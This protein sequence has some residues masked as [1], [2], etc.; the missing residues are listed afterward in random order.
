[1]PTF[2]VTGPLRR[3]DASHSW[4]ARVEIVA[5]GNEADVRNL[6]V[7]G[8]PIDGVFT[9]GMRRVHLPGTLL[10]RVRVSDVRVEF[11]A[12]IVWSWAGA[13]RPVVTLLV[14]S[15]PEDSLSLEIADRL[16]CVA[17]EIALE[18]PNATV[19]GNHATDWPQRYL[20]HLANVSDL[21]A[22]SSG[23][24]VSAS[25]RL[26]WLDAADATASA[27]ARFHILFPPQ[28][29]PGNWMIS[30]DR[31]SLTAAA[32]AS[33]VEKFAEFDRILTGARTER[34]PAEPRPK[35]VRLS[36]AGGEIPQFHYLTRPAANPPETRLILPGGATR[37]IVCAQ[38]D[39]G[40]DTLQVAPQLT[41]KAD[42]NGQGIPTGLQFTLNME[43][44]RPVQ[45]PL[46]SGFAGF[47]AGDEPPI[48]IRAMLS[49]DDGV[50]AWRDP[51][52][53]T[54]AMVTALASYQ[55]TV[56]DAE[57]RNA[58]LTLLNL[59]R[60]R[61][62]GAFGSVAYVA[63][64]PAAPGGDFTESFDIENLTTVYDPFEAATA[65]RAREGLPTPDLDASPT[66]ANCGNVAIT[67]SV[68]WGVLPLA[69]GWAQ[70]PFL[71]L[72][73]ETFLR[74]VDFDESERPLVPTLLQGAATFGNESPGLWP[75]D[76][77]ENRWS[78]SLLDAARIDG[79]WTIRRD[80]GLAWRP[81]RLALRFRDPEAVINGLLQLATKPPSQADCL[82]DFDAWLTA[83][84]RVSLRTPLDDDRFRS[85]YD[86]VLERIRLARRPF[87]L[88]F[89]FDAGAVPTV[90]HPATRRSLTIV[91]GRMTWTG[92]EIG[93]GVLDQLNDWKEDAAYGA[94]FRGALVRLLDR[95]G[96]LNGEPYT[97]IEIADWK[98]E[99]RP[100]DLLTVFGES[101]HYP[102]VHIKTP[103]PLV[104][105]RHPTLPAVQSLPMTQVGRPPVY[106]SANRQLVPFQFGAAWKFTG[107]TGDW[108]DVENADLQVAEEWAAAGVGTAF[109]PLSALSL[110]GLAGHAADQPV[111]EAPIGDDFLPWEY[112]YGLPYLDE[113]YALAGLP[114]EPAHSDD[115]LVSTSA[116]GPPPVES[117]TPGRDEY[118]AY[119]S[120]LAEKGFLAAAD[121]DGAI[122][123]SDGDPNALEVTGLV[124][125][126]RWPIDVDVDVGS[127]PGSLTFT[128]AG[129]SLTIGRDDA[130]GLP[131]RGIDAKFQLNVGGSLQLD[132][133]GPFS[134]VSG[135]LA[136]KE[137]GG[138]R[139]DQRGLTH[140]ATTGSPIANPEVATTVLRFH[141]APAAAETLL[142][143][144]SLFADC[145]LSLGSLDGAVWRL[146]FRDLP[147]DD[148]DGFFERFRSGSDDR[149]GVNDPGA[150]GR[151]YNFRNGYEWRLAGHDNRLGPFD[152]F[153][154]TLEKVKFEA[155][156]V[157]AVE[158]TGRLQLPQVDD[159]GGA[160]RRPQAGVSNAV[161]LSF[162]AGGG[163]ALELSAVAIEPP[164]SIGGATVAELVWPLAATEG[165]PRVVIRRLMYTA[166]GIQMD[167]LRL[168]FGLFG[169][170][171]SVAPITPPPVTSAT[172]GIELRWDNPGLVDADAVGVRSVLASLRFPTAVAAPHSLTLE[173]EGRWGNPDTARIEARAEWNLISTDRPRTTRRVLKFADRSEIELLPLSSEDSR[174][175]EG[176]FQI[177]WQSLGVGASPPDL[178]PGFTPDPDKAPGYAVLTFISEPAAVA[179]S[180]PR[181]V[182][183]SGFMEGIFRCRRPGAP[184]DA[185][186]VFGSSEGDVDAGL[187]YR[188][189]GSSWRESLLLNGL[190]TIRNLISWPD[191]D[192][193]ALAEDPPRVVLPST[194]PIASRPLTHYRHS[195]KV[196][197]N[198]VELTDDHLA[199]GTRSVFTLADSK[200]V[201]SFPT[202]V[203]HELKRVALA[204]DGATTPE[205]PPAI[206]QT[207]DVRTWTAM[208]EVRLLRPRFFRTF[209]ERFASGALFAPPWKNSSVLF[210]AL[211]FTFDGYLH[212]SFLDQVRGSTILETLDDGGALLVEMSSVVGLRSLSEPAATAP[213]SDIRRSLS[214][215]LQAASAT[216]DDFASDPS[217]RSPWTPVS[218]PFLSRLQNSADD[219]LS[220]DSVT[221]LRV[222]PLLI[223]HRQRLAG[224]ALCRTSLNLASRADGQNVSLR[225]G[226]FDAPARQAI[227]RL[228][229]ATLEEQWFRLTTAAESIDRDAPAGGITAAPP[230]D[231][232][233]RLSRPAFLERLFDPLRVAV[234]P[235]HG[236]QVDPEPESILWRYGAL[237]VQDFLVPNSAAAA[238]SFHGAGAQ[239]LSALRRPETADSRSRSIGVTLLP[240]PMTDRPTPLLLQPV[241][242]AVCPYRGVGLLPPAA[243]LTE[244]AAVFTEILVRER[245]GT[246]PVVLRARLWQKGEK[247]EQPG[248]SEPIDD[249]LIFAWATDLWER[250]AGD[251]LVCVLRMR[252]FFVHPN[253]AAAPPGATIRIAYRFELLARSPSDRQPDFEPSPIRGELG[254][255][256]FAEPGFSENEPPAGAT[257]VGL[258]P[259]RVRSVTPQYELTNPLRAFSGITLDIDFTR[260][261]IGMTGPLLGPAEWRAWWQ[262][263][264]LR[265]QFADPSTDAQATL[266][267]NF[268]SRAIRSLAVA[269]PDLPLPA[270]G[271]LPASVGGPSPPA[272]WQPVLPGSVRWTGIGS[273]AGAF[274]TARPQIISQPADGPHW[275]SGSVPVQHRFPRPVPI[276]KNAGGGQ[277]EA[278][279]P[280]AEWFDLDDASLVERSVAA[281]FRPTDDAF[282]FPAGGPAG[283][284]A[285]FV[286]PFDFDRGAVPLERWRG[287]NTPEFTLRFDKLGNMATD[288]TSDIVLN[289]GDFTVACA[290]AAA[291]P[292]DGER[293]YRVQ[294][295]T[296]EIAARFRTWL[297]GRSH[298]DE[299][300]LELSVRPTGFAIDGLRQVLRLTSRFASASALPVPIV[301]VAIRFE[302]PAYNGSLQ[303]RTQRRVVVISRNVPGGS[304]QPGI[305]TI[306]IDRER[307]NPDSTIHLA[308]KVEGFSQSGTETPTQFRAFMDLLKAKVAIYRIREGIRSPA[309]GSY[310]P[311]LNASAGGLPRSTLG[312]ISFPLTLTPSAAGDALPL[313]VEPGDVVVVGFELSG[314]ISGESEQMKDSALEVPVVADPV[315]PSVRRAFALLRMNHSADVECRRFAWSPSAARIELVN[316]DDIFQPIVRRRGVF[317]WLDT[318]RT[319]AEVAYALQ[320][321][322]PTGA[323]LIPNAFSP[324][325]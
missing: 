108:S 322:T 204:I 102:D 234:P 183:T 72:T 145:S 219:G 23:L 203:E 55:R 71:N 192:R 199:A 158:L 141:E 124:E 170:R 19:F 88:E 304:P 175:P 144:T 100:N 13:Q 211:K 292:V 236:P 321:I 194:T 10:V 118:A 54:D 121:T 280:W 143:L 314:V 128:D 53:S 130:R 174:I 227:S 297:A 202:V 125:P 241:S 224:E 201:F 98:L 31:E 14:Q 305:L 250:L 152:F 25:A 164:D 69:R 146:W 220:T 289:C 66:V 264:A 159:Q 184:H 302:D 205:S 6:H 173:L 4:R 18:H 73:E 189:D 109:L 47:P 254:Q 106:P 200:G 32:G 111:A 149:Q 33:F 238:N 277:A 122:V 30:L 235:Q 39:A 320:A 188:L 252:E 140:G 296:P 165:A 318:I 40:G 181:L 116:A 147:V 316:P 103:R 56:A 8:E 214:G 319:T 120:V 51:E 136:A 206:L 59:V 244:R 153:P 110:P 288:W 291:G 222:D 41:L 308:F 131:L 272:S 258:N 90:M 60:K 35:W 275:A 249:Q 5:R 29:E 38:P 20:P 123:P 307:I 91:A 22:T 135:S 278:L 207:D 107:T 155:G 190:I 317:R 232:A 237:A 230:T 58:V 27:L 89:A 259:P 169:T 253:P 101:K 195:A 70:L 270:D 148:S 113:P 49:T 215:T 217:G 97:P 260:E 283:L 284:R 75:L 310:Q 82:P 187:T 85:P 99:Y 216:R 267:K 180:P 247:P 311:V 209:L 37:L 221:R 303:S 290:S 248:V 168:E 28:L 239:L 176:A 117:K 323:T 26:P 134:I 93:I 273:R 191:F 225:L 233:A 231:A 74:S 84:H 104:W 46:P 151:R 114:Q 226:R 268:R 306:G 309:A 150:S 287:G 154:L 243:G 67:P 269:L 261:R 50:L 12:P 166:A 213:P 218:V 42:E 157:R 281:G 256:R 64:A 17:G 21:R 1:M 81:G 179:G 312:T 34:Q 11:P 177:S 265:V 163:D 263:I 271:N 79:E 182:A 68:L 112:H 78:V 229:P 87:R 7:C 126:Y 325:S 240:P 36:S 127:Y 242:F 139:R 129:S 266:P 223:L 48:S 138:E 279:A 142:K 52:G 257:P 300:L 94:S 255:L 301:P 160:I 262:S 83:L 324:P 156:A 295:N 80:A 172:R 313:P 162:L 285:E 63:E 167:L 212:A 9:D 132:A 274:F 119:W 44:V 65:L 298:G 208:H 62:A 197:L 77:R 282:V 286:D 43:A 315:T 137:A 95:L 24:S 45:F 245:N 198:D 57:L 3:H 96:R 186:S 92:T 294:P 16:R 276:P 251:S 293:T 86:V 210:T 193:A 246:S 178:L 115:G 15:R 2:T 185:Q 161:R 299:F 61:R 228:D 105:R 171:W 133:A 76:P 196:L